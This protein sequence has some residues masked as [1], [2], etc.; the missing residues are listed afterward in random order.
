[1]KADLL[2]TGG[3]EPDLSEAE[4]VRVPL[5]GANLGSGRFSQGLASRALHSARLR[6]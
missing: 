4:P 3:A 5:L 6:S 2:P 1:M